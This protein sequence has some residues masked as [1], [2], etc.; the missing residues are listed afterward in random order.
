[1]IV[2]SLE[3]VLKPVPFLNPL[4]SFPAIQSWLKRIES[5]PKSIEITDARN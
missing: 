4:N 3:I 1:M 2:Y 5:Q